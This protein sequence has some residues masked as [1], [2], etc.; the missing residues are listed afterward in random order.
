MPQQT[1]AS[2]PIDDPH[3]APVATPPARFTTMDG[4]LV[5]TMIIWG[6]HYSVAKVAVDTLPPFVFNAFRLSIGVGMSF[7]LLKASGE[8]LTISRRAIPRLVITALLLY[9]A[10]QL[11]FLNGLRLTVVSHSVLINSI[12]PAGV[13]LANI[14]LKR[15]RGTRRIYLGMAMAL[16]GVVVVVLSRFSDNLGFADTTLYGDL[17]TFLGVLLWIVITLSMR[18]LMSNNPV[19]ATSFWMLVCGVCIVYVIA[20]PDLM[21]FDWSTLDWGIVAAIVFSG[22]IAMSLAGTLWNLGLRKLGA[23]RTANYV[24]LQPIVA[25]IFAALFLNE[26]LTVWLIIGI[27]LVLYGMSRVQLG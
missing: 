25:A 2:I 20:L 21:V 17:L 19:L 22:A 8:K 1:I 27:C 15:E 18:T 5:L 23:S 13:V 16:I 7:I 14:F 4:L 9:G 6:T 24:N 12:A 3:A 10:Y 11:A 26:A